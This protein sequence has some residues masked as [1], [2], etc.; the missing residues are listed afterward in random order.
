MAVRCGAFF[1]CCHVCS[2]C[3]VRGARRR[4]GGGGGD[5]GAS[6]ACKLFVIVCLLVF[7]MALVG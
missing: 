4:G 6:V 1:M 7:L 5:G 2:Q 3:V